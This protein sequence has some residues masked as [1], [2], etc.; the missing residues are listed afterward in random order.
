MDQIPG[1][2]NDDHGVGYDGDDCKNGPNDTIESLYQVERTQ[3][4][5]CIHY[6]AVGGGQAAVHLHATHAIGVL[7]SHFRMRANLVALGLRKENFQA[8]EELHIKF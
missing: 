7:S 1:E 6:V 4:G 2:H 3:P 8:K 5:S